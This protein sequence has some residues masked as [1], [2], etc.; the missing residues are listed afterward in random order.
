MNFGVIKLGNTFE[1]SVGVILSLQERL[2]MSFALDQRLTGGTTQNGVNL[3]GS[4]LNAITFN[5]G[6]TYVIPPRMTVDFVVGIGLSRDAPDASVLV[7]VPI[8]F[9]LGKQ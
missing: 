5:I 9:K 6:A 1:Y 7:R 3:P 2:S 4:S 8:L